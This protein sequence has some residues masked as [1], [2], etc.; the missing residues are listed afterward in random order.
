[1]N[2][3]DFSMPAALFLRRAA[4][5]AKVIAIVGGGFTGTMVMANLFR[6]ATSERLPLHIIL[7]DRQSTI[8]EGTAYRTSDACHLLNVPV[9]RMSAWP[10]RPD[11]FLCFARKWNPSVQPD[12]FL[13]RRFYGE[14]VRAELFRLSA[15]APKHLSAEIVHGE[16]ANLEKVI[17][18][19]WRI[20][21]TDGRAMRADLVVLTVGHRPPDDSQICDRWSGPR[22]CF[23]ADPWNTAVLSQ[24]GPDEPVL[25]IGS[26]LTAVDIVLTLTARERKAPILAISRH[27]LM[28]RAHLPHKTADI[29]LSALIADLLDP[30]TP[31]TTRRLMK[32]LRRTVAAV[33]QLGVPWQAVVDALRIATSR[34]WSLL[35]NHEKARFLRHVRP[36]WEIHRHRMPPAVANSIDQL[37]RDGRLKVIAGRLITAEA[38]EEGVDVGYLCRGTST[39]SHLRVTWVVNCTGPGAH[40]RHKTHGFLRPLVH[41]G[42]LCMDDLGLGVLTDTCGRAMSEVDG[43]RSD[44]FVAG[45]LRKATLWEST[46]V[47]ELRQQAREVARTAIATLSAE[48]SASEPTLVETGVISQQPAISK[49]LTLCPI[50]ELSI[51]P[52]SKSW[53][54]DDNAGDSKFHAIASTLGSRHVSVSKPSYAATNNAFACVGQRVS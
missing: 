54:D 53:S 46:A 11:D 19:E 43:P 3:T 20:T 17:P 44:L 31:L 7:I 24:I 37:Q 18:S 26:G 13:P 30:G 28:P 40:H 1:M 9:A 27:G 29:D 47:P 22:S 25:L 35:D 23:V 50:A 39:Q 10:D 41:Q 12:D 42:I 52:I 2:D 21:T 33:R 8:G 49:P 51:S 5:G 36:Y 38:D 48:G 6:F 16:V 15:S 4:R 45:T 34:L 32:T 14:Y